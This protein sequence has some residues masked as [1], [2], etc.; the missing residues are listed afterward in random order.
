L[1][2][3]LGVILLVLAVLGVASLLDAD[4]ETDGRS[5]PETTSAPTGD[6]QANEDGT[7]APGNPP[8]TGLPQGKFVEI[9]ETV[10]LGR[11]AG[12]VRDLLVEDGLKPVVENQFGKEPDDYGRCMVDEVTPNG[13]QQVGT[14]VFVHCE[15][16]E[17]APR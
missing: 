3:V 11:P 12:L 15:E 4:R 17:E 2:I 6:G 10:Y 1:L 7:D 13:R 8:M 14:E 9:D 5:T 16:D